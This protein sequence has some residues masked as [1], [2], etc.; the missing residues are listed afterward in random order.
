MDSKINRTRKEILFLLIGVFI[1]IILICS[2]MIVSLKT[3]PLVD[4]RNSTLIVQSFYINGTILVEFPAPTGWI[5]DTKEI[6]YYEDEINI[7]KNK[8]GGL[9]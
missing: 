8:L 7:F 9:K 2:F 5:K 6:C 3:I 4:S 1:G